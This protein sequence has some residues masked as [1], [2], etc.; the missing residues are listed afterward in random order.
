[1]QQQSGIA[2]LHAI[3]LGKGRQACSG[4]VKRRGS[5]AGR[6]NL[7]QGRV[8]STAGQQLAAP[9]LPHP[10]TH[11]PASIELGQTRP[12]KPSS[13]ERKRRS[14]PKGLPASAP[15][16]QQK[17]SLGPGVSNSVPSRKLSGGRRADKPG[18]E[19]K[20]ARLARPVVSDTAFAHN[21]ALSWKQQRVAS[22]PSSHQT[23]HPSPAAACPRA[24]SG[25][26]AACRRAARKPRGSAAS[27]SIAPSA[28]GGGGRRTPCTRAVEMLQDSRNSFTHALPARRCEGCKTGKP[29]CSLGCSPW[30]MQRPGFPPSPAEA[31]PR[32]VTCA[33]CR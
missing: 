21:G 14:T 33:G 4:C 5:P 31:L 15:A 24:A 6:P 7:N 10:P 27:G 25:L 30:R 32:P 16:A 3:A 2:Q 23:P 1:M 28:W 20:P 29:R 8:M 18:A 9:A 22:P 12:S 26:P 11:P 19:E 17:F 13:C